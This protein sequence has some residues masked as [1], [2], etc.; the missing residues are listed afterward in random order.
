MYS[1]RLIPP[2]RPLGSRWHAVA[3]ASIAALA[4][5]ILLSFFVDALH[6]SIARGEAL[7]LALDM[8]P[9][10]TASVGN[11]ASPASASLQL[12]GR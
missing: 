2:P 8:A 9:P 12:A 5:C 7:R 4:A 10:A 11:L 3:L 6:L 1:S